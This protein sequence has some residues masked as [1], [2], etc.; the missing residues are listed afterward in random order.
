MTEENKDIKPK[1]KR[2]STRGRYGTPEYVIAISKYFNEAFP[3]TI[4]A[5]WIIDYIIKFFFAYI[6]NELKEDRQVPVFGIG[7]F[8]LVKRMRKTKYGPFLQYTP[9]LK[10]SHHFKTRIRGYKGT[11]TEAELRVLKQRKEFMAGVWEKRKQYV[12][13]RKGNL[14]YLNPLANPDTDIPS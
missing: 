12:A 4:P 9:K 13:A 14:D 3:D 8:V 5:D 7:R 2:T 11:N 1:Q 6:E 10:Y